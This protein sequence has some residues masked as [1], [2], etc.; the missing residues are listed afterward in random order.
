[1][2]LMTTINVYDDGIDD[3]YGGDS[4]GWKCDG[5]GRD[6]LSGGD[7][8]TMNTIIIKMIGSNRKT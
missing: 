2:M 1:M 3:D 8:V 5:D 4:D 6:Y 7:V